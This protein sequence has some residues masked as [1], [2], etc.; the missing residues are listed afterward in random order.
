[1][2]FELK[3]SYTSSDLVKIMSLLRGEGGCPWDREQTHSSIRDNFIEETLE[4]VEAIDNSD[5]ALLKEELGDVLLQIVFHSQIESEAGS[6]CFDDVCDGICKKLIFRHP[7][8]FGDKSAS[9]SSDVLKIW[10]EAKRKEK[11]QST[12]AETLEAVPKT[13]P[14]LMRAQKVQKRA[15]KSGFD[16]PELSFAWEDLESEL[17]ELSEAIKNKDEENIKEELGDV[18]F[19]V[20]NV[21]RLLGLNGEDAL[22]ASTKKFIKRFSLLEEIASKNK[23]VLESCSLDE[24]NE[25]WDQ[26]KDILKK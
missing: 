3:K 20:C 1:M 6:F 9:D 5:V 11:S 19:S 12:F 26:A 23:I 14:S 2:D 13:F 25:L 10:D 16:Y 22:N 8:I 4:A 15:A 7:H 18:L 24:L 17:D 21:S